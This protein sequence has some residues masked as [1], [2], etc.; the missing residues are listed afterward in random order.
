MFV[1]K[2]VGS[3]IDLTVYDCFTGKVRLLQ[4]TKKEILVEVVDVQMCYPCQHP[5]SAGERHWIPKGLILREPTK[6]QSWVL[7]AQF[8]INRFFRSFFKKEDASWRS[9]FPF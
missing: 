4:K 7:D 5:A 9:E 1:T 2:P 3:I 6:L 8:A